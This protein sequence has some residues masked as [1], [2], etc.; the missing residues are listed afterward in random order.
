M[1]YSNTPSKSMRMIPISRMSR[2]RVNQMRDIDSE[3]TEGQ[4]EGKL[5]FWNPVTEQYEWIEPYE[6]DIVIASPNET[7]YKLVVSDAGVLSTEL[8]E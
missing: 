4:E 2:S 5:L 3:S 6:I 8:I 1:S 7:L